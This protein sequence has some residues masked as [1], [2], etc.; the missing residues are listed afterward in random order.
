M[1]LT[2][3]N[4]VTLKGTAKHVLLFNKLALGLLNIEAKLKV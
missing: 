1:S 2:L 3:V 4:F